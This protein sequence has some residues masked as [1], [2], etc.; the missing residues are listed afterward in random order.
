MAF[1]SSLTVF[2][3]KVVVV[4]VVDHV[5]FGEG[6]ANLTVVSLPLP[7]AVAS[8]ISHDTNSN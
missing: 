7:V 3:F 6:L 2:V 4:V 1:C 5:L 8:T